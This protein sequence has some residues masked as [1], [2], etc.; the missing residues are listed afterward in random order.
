MRSVM[1]KYLLPFI[2]SALCFVS[3]LAFFSRLVMPKYASESREG[4]LIAEYY[5]AADAGERHD[6]IFF[7]DCE[8]YSSFVPPILYEKYGIKSF[9]RASP[10][11]SIAQTY[12]LIAE[13]LEYERPQAVVLSVYALC[14]TDSQSEAYNRMTLDGMRISRSKLAAIRES[15]GEDESLLSYVLPVLRFHSRI[16]SL[17]AEDFTYLFTRPRVSHNGYFMEKRIKAAEKSAEEPNTPT[18]PLPAQNLAYLERITELCRKKGTELILVKAPISSWRYPW[19]S[20]WSEELERYAARESIKYYD[21]LESADEIGIDLSTDTYDG[22]LH[23]NVWGAEKTTTYFGAILRD[24][25][26]I[27]GGES[28]AFEEGQQEYYKERNCE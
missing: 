1:K 21:L 11:Q 28:L 24:S 4:N 12:H 14:R 7:G 10:A 16:Y 25:C 15:A 19:Y 9:V 26:G 2:I 18:S 23:L 8:A 13:T 17:G 20:E 27:I 5:R 3:L 6:V 22:G